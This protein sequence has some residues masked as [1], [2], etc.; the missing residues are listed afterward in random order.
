[1][2]LLCTSM[3]MAALITRLRQKLPGLWIF[4]IT[5]QIHSADIY[6]VLR[7]DLKFRTLQQGSRTVIQIKNT[8]SSVEFQ[9][10]VRDFTLPFSYFYAKFQ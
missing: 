3:M 1:N 6:S 2:L 4:L 8:K 9:A 5:L 10:H 7:E